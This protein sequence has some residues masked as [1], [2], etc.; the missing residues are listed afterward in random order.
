MP[1]FTTLIAGV[2]AAITMSTYTLAATPDQESAMKHLASYVGSWESTGKTTDAFPNIPAGKDYM[3]IVE[4]RWNTAMDTVLS[5][6]KVETTDGTILSIGT[7]MLTWSPDHKTLVIEYTGQDKGIPFHGSATL[8]KLSGNASQWNC[9]ERDAKGNEIWYISTDTF[10]SEPGNQWTSSMQPCDSN[11]KPKGDSNTRQMSRVNMFTRNCGP[12]ADLMGTWTWKTT[13]GDGTPMTMTNTYEWG[14][15]ERSILCRF[16][17]T[18]KGETTLIACESIYSSEDGKGVRGDYWNN[19]GD[20]VDWYITRMEQ[21]GSNAWWTSTFWGTSADGTPIN[22]EIRVQMT[23]SERMSYTFER[24]S[25][26]GT[27]MPT[28]DLNPKDRLFKR[29]SSIASAPTH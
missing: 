13:D 22:G 28:S 15:G 10:P 18:T 14:P 17:E 12:V 27:D 25:Y 3:E 16:Y 1:S 21:N 7:G 20:N 19:K 29:V 5:N 26:G 9:H 2:A 4:Y 8:G 24:M 11:W 6:W 23:D